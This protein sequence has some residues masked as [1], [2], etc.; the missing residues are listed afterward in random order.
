MIPQASYSST[1]KNDK[2]TANRNSSKTAYITLIQPIASRIVNL[3]T[4]FTKEYHSRL[5]HTIDQK[6]MV[7]RFFPKHRT[8]K[9]KIKVLIKSQ[10]IFKVLYPTNKTRQELMSII[11]QNVKIQCI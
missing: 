6:A 3:V 4:L 9:F 1:D 2:Y 11:I 8:V 10:I 5:A 7:R